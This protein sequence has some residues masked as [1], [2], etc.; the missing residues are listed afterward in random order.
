MQIDDNVLKRGIHRQKSGF[1]R[2]KNARMFIHTYK[3]H[4]D[5]FTT[6]AGVLNSKT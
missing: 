4:M 6:Q 2:A 1:G 5:K 3:K